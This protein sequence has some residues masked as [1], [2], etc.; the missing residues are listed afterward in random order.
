MPVERPG[1]I[2]DAWLYRLWW[3]Q[4]HLPESNARGAD[5]EV[6]DKEIRVKGIKV[7]V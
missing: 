3:Q 1:S 5:Q 4:G 7:L 6:C 2:A